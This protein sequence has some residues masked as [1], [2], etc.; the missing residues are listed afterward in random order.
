MT[1][2]TWGDFPIVKMAG[3]KF[4]EVPRSM[5]PFTRDGDG[6]EVVLMPVLPPDDKKAFPGL[7]PFE[8]FGPFLKAG[9]SQHLFDSTNLPDVWTDGQATEKFTARNLLV[10]D[11][12]NWHGECFGVLEAHGWT[13]RGHLKQEMIERIVEAEGDADL[14][15]KAKVEYGENYETYLEELAA[16]HFAPPLSR[17]WY[18][19]NMMALYY[20][21]YDDMR[22]GYLWAEYQIK[23]RA[24]IFALKHIELIE[25]NRESGMKGGQADKKIERYSVLDQLGRRRFKELAFASDRDGV[26]VAKRI[27]ADHDKN[28]DTPLFRVNGKDLSRNWYSDWLAH[29]RQ[30]ARG[31]E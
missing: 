4:Q 23:M 17:L 2:G 31:I 25:R 22:F 16:K 24:E 20:C 6:D 7:P 1:K 30:I 29:F 14:V 10:L 19:A 11:E 15:S 18:V 12:L 13:E 3:R 9:I 26:R 28:A 8:G 27:A 5:L 21:H